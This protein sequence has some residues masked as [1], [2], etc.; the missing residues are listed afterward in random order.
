[1]TTSKKNST[2][3]G[4]QGLIISASVPGVV[5]MFLAGPGAQ[6]LK[7]NLVP[8]TASYSGEWICNCNIMNPVNDCACVLS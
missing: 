2:L 1:M 5:A 6:A 3:L 7:A 4:R 8:G